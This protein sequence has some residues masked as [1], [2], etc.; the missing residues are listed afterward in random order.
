MQ[1]TSRVR[2]AVE[3]VDREVAR[4]AGHTSVEEAPRLDG[5]RASWGK[6]VDLL[7]LGPPPE[8]RECPHCGCVGMLDA[9]RCGRCWMELAPFDAEPHMTRDLV[10]QAPR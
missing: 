2:R 5:L 1:L 3:A 9:T 8:R 7:A 4:L 10:G 6:L